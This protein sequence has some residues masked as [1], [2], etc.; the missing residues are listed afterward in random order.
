MD[1]LNLTDEQMQQVIRF[2]LQRMGL[3]TRHELMI[4]LPMAYLALYPSTGPAVLAKIRTAINSGI[5]G[6]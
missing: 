4:H 6:E 3:D 1:R 2:L 5:E